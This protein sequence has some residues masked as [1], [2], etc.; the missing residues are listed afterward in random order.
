MRVVAWA[1]ESGTSAAD[2]TAMRDGDGSPESVMG[3]GQIAKDLGLHPGIGSIMGQG[4]E[5]G[6]GNGPPDEDR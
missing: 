4:G 5:H 2:I 3:W 6:Q 1:A